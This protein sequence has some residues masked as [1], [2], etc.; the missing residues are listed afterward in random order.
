MSKPE[1]LFP[2]DQALGIP[3]DH[4]RYPYAGGR[5][6]RRW[7]SRMDLERP[8]RAAAAAT[9]ATLT[10]AQKKI[11]ACRCLCTQVNG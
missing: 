2:M 1:A 5:G 6:R 7:S 4:D 3:V 10:F 8:G 11:A 9:H